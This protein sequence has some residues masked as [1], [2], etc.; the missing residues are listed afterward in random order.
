MRVLR[1]FIVLLFF[2]GFYTANAQEYKWAR[3]AIDSMSGYNYWWANSC[4]SC[5]GIVQNNTYAWYGNAGKR[6]STVD[7]DGNTYVIGSFNGTVKIGN[8]VLISNNVNN[9]NLCGYAST[10]Y[11]CFD[12]YVAKYDST[13]QALWAVSAGGSQM[14]LANAIAVDEEGY[15]YVGGT[16]NGTNAID[17]NFGPNLKLNP[18]GQD[19]FVAK[20][21][22]AGQW[23]WA[24]K[25]TG[26]SEECVSAVEVDRYG[27]CYVAGSGSGFIKVTSS[28][29]ASTPAFNG[30]RDVFLA[31]ISPTGL[32]LW[33]RSGGGAE[34][35]YP[36]DITIDNSG[37]IYLTAN[38]YADATFSQGAVYV[39]LTGTQSYG[40][41][42]KYSVTGVPIWAKK[43]GTHAIAATTDIYGDILVTGV[44][45]TTTTFGTT[46][47]VP[48][49]PGKHDVYIAKISSAGDFEWTKRIGSDEN[50][51]A[52]NYCGDNTGDWSSDI[53]V[54]PAGN[55]YVSG[56]L[57]D[58][59]E[60]GSVCQVTRV[61]YYPY[62]GNNW[63]R[64]G[65]VIKINSDGTEGWNVRTRGWYGCNENVN[66][67]G[68]DYFGNVYF[69]GTSY[70]YTNSTNSIYYPLAL[71]KNNDSIPVGTLGSGFNYGWYGWYWGEYL[72]RFRNTEVITTNSINKTAYCVGDS[73]VV[74][75]TKYGTF[76]NGNVFTLQL[77]DSSGDFNNPLVLGTLNTVNSGEFR[78]KLPSNLLMGVGYRVR[79]VGSLPNIVGYPVNKTFI[80]STYAVANAGADKTICL[81]DSVQITGN[82][83]WYNQW[84]P[85]VGVSN[86]NGKSPYFKPVNS[87]EYIFHTWNPGNCGSYDTVNVTVVARPKATVSGTLTICE[88]DTSTLT[89]TSANGTSF[90]WSPLYNIINPSGSVARVYPNQDTTYTLTVSNGIC[91]DTTNVRLK[92]NRLPQVSSLPD[93]S[94]CLNDT[95]RL[96]FSS[97]AASFTW[98]PPQTVIDDQTGSP[99]L[100]PATATQ[101]TLTA[102]SDKGCI[103]QRS[104]H[105]DVL[106]LP[107]IQI[108]RDTF[109]CYRE[110]VTIQ[111]LSP[112]TYT[113]NSHTFIESWDSTGRAIVRPLATG[114]YTVKGFNGVCS[115]TASVYVSVNPLPGVDAG[116]DTSLCIGSNVYL[117]AKGAVSYQ[118]NASAYI[119]DTT[120]ASPA[121][122]PVST[123]F[124]KVKGT[125]INGCVNFDSVKVIVHALPPVSASL[126]T[127]VCPGQR[128]MIFAGGALNYKWTPDVNI[129]STNIP[130]PE[131]F[132]YAERFYKVK[133]TDANGCIAYDS[134]KISMKPL[135]PANAGLDTSIC[136]GDKASLTGSGGMEYL[137][138]P[139]SNLS[140]ASSS[141][142][143]AQPLIST[144]YTLMV[145]GVN[146]CYGFDSVTVYVRQLPQIN[147]SVDQTICEKDSVLL[148][149]NSPTGSTFEWRNKAGQIVSGSASF[150]AI[151]PATDEYT[152]KTSDGTCTS[153][154]ESVN[155]KVEPIPSPAF[156]TDIAE[157]KYPL[158]VKF[159]NQSTGD[160]VSYL[161][162]FGDSIGV[163]TD[164]D[165]SYTYTKPGNYKVKLKA[166][167]SKGC[168]QEYQFDGIR[169][170]DYSDI[171]IP[172]AFS[173]NEDGLNDVFQ[174]TT[175]EMKW[176]RMIILNKWGQ[177]IYEGSWSRG[178]APLTWD[179][180]FNNT[181]VQDGVYVYTIEAKGFDD[182]YRYLKGE[183]TLLR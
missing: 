84:S 98:S 119:A 118:W 111:P 25:L 134:V 112:L 167:T 29:T 138:N 60:P 18:Q 155:V 48:F 168:W 120:I 180:R 90:S 67:I 3:K 174:V 182:K 97:D 26:A 142:T 131:V 33:M 53:E 21:S 81:S 171:H 7:A 80:I 55:I 163:S 59:T 34:D 135:P 89:S 100:F 144:T 69:S 145:K 141:N 82:N 24:H 39:P 57:V 130:N 139:I 96:Y 137:W 71:F 152:V 172:T 140:N 126:D 127:V 6:N 160:I 181:P 4:N 178:Q 72:S 85:S 74:S 58:D 169:V 161:W 94:M 110:A 116:Q 95:L 44:Y 179:G 83:G 158:E 166:F 123:S 43:I 121:V 52:G 150:W 10:G 173:P 164:R 125:D 75:Y 143:Y 79:V 35:E 23:V 38:F 91:S 73:M 61:R 149:A 154:G 93:T 148:S 17:V 147:A 104:L 37:N 9:C 5:N 92:I 51:T 108:T 2:S 86:A 41:I 49:A 45:N 156:K 56:T 12:F 15:V 63:K 66:G 8:N 1:F 20:I 88:K 78:V 65:F 47:F 107:Q 36:S 157:G 30:K 176:M 162:D 16:I 32:P 99:K 136:R 102:T 105:V 113:W 27:N 117:N 122:N 177:I 165:P 40:A 13:G 42:I 170:Y 114:R 22:P 28:L 54:D 64:A 124:F 14:D 159:T 132:P 46:T 50:K 31:K 115:D 129:N 146:G 68:L 133:G 87:Q 151:P 19:G 11:Y 175:G 128:I 77:S 106:A 153:L 76:Q 103:L 70:M 101:Y 183:I 62:I 109:T